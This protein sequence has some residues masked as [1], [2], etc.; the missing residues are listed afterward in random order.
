MFAADLVRQLTVPVRLHQLGFDSYAG[1]PQSGAVRITLDVLAPLNGCH[2]LLL[3]GAIISGRTPKYLASMLALRQPASMKICA[4]GIKSGPRAV[5]LPI[6]YVGFELGPEFAI[7]YG[8]GS[9]LERCFAD[10]V[11][12]DVH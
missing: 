7:G 11:E 3:E 9:G 12:A 10:I 1:Q 2:I 4:L 6:D 8:M 5:N